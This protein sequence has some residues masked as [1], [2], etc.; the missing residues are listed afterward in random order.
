MGV[1]YK[2]KEKDRHVINKCESTQFIRETVCNFTVV[3]VWDLQAIVV[4]DEATWS[5]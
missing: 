1:H 2:D 4:S 5:G 3:A